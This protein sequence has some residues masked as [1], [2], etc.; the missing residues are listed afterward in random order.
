MSL[1]NDILSAVSVL[2]CDFGEMT[3]NDYVAVA[4]KAGVTLGEV[5]TVE[6][7]RRT[8][9]TEVE[10]L[11]AVKCAFA[12]NNK[13]LDIGLSD[14]VS[15]L[16]GTVG[17]DLAVMRK[18]ERRLLGDAFI[19]DAVRYTLGSQVGNHEIGLEPCAG[20]GDSCGYTGLARAILEHMED[21]TKALRAIALMV[22][23]GTL[24]RVG[25]TTTGCNMEGF[26]AAAAATA[27]S[28]AE[29]EGGTPAQCSQAL[30]LAISPTVAVPCVPRISVPGLCATHIAGAILIGTLSARLA[31]HTSMPVTVDAD[32]MIAMAAAVHPVSAQYVVPV[33]VDYMRPFFKR[34]AQVELFVAP[35]V[36]DGEEEHAAVMRTRVKEE[37]K[38]LVV[39][40][41]PISKPFGVAVVGGSSQAVGSP[42]N[43]GRIAHELISGD[44]KKITIELYPELFSRRGTNVPGILMGAVL[45]A[46]T[47][48]VQAYRTVMEKIIQS[49]IAIEVKELAVPQI[50]KITL[51]TTGGTFFVDTRNRG[52]GRVHLVD[53]TPSLRAAYDVA[54]RL[55]IEAVE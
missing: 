35:D 29:L 43:M 32:T 23:I 19:D 30:A 8:G 49:C 47:K 3:I 16:L 1:E 41:N 11:Q 44:I 7:M 37:V 12:H 34:N 45:G 40:S 54:V 52:G 48:D 21:E 39:R 5:V 31:V 33:T 20:T 51:E 4:E 15:Y 2:G 46:T 17:N 14:G 50:Q 27:A 28:V 6:E 53:A 25:K 55:G 26:G 38:K 24:F 9:K 13:A 10:I 22:K 36:R 42:T 18:S